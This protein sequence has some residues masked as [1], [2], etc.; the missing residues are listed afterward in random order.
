MRILTILTM[1]VCV[2]CIVG[3]KKPLIGKSGVLN[4]MKKIAIVLCVVK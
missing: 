2:C 3:K 4:I 1:G